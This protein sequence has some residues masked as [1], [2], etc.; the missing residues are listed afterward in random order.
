MTPLKPLTITER[1]C[2]E[3][4]Q[5][6]WGYRGLYFHR[7]DKE[8]KSLEFMENSQVVT[9]QSLFALKTDE[10][11]FDLFC[12]AYLVFVKRTGWAAHLWDENLLDEKIVECSTKYG[13]PWNRTA[14]HIFI[15][16]VER[17]FDGYSSTIHEDVYNNGSITF[18][19][20]KH[21]Y[22]LMADYH[23]ELLYPD[24]DHMR[25]HMVKLSG[26]E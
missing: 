14:R 10:E 26:D 18:E 9:L 25:K 1:I 16:P 13:D 5:H 2:S 23:F 19:P 22:N 20:L 15:D 4:E 8:G 6:L 7:D 11:Q 21:V 12:Y 24:R 17:E 3:K